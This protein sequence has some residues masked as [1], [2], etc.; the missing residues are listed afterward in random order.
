MLDYRRKIA[1]LTSDYHLLAERV[2]SFERDMHSRIQCVEAELMPQ[3]W[4]GYCANCIPRR[5]LLRNK[6]VRQRCRFKTRMRAVV[7]PLPRGRAGGLAR[8]K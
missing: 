8:A 1:Q 3:S 6:A 2:A 5:N 7:A 4:T